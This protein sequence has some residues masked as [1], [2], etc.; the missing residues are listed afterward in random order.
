MIP[1]PGG[2]PARWPTA[3]V[4]LVTRAQLK[5]DPA[6]RSSMW[7]DLDAPRSTEVDFLNGALARLGDASGVSV[8][9]N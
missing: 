8:P 3:L 6:A 2:K 4:R 9:F 1:K 7:Q 5:V